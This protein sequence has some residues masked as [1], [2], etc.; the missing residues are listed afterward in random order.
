[1]HT[2]APPSFSHIDL[3][4]ENFSA[5]LARRPKKVNGGNDQWSA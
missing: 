5:S 4:I 2:V 3:K 1:M